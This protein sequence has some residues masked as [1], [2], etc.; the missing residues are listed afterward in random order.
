MHV[1]A[2]NI[3]FESTDAKDRVY[4]LMGILTEI[5]GPDISNLEVDYRKS[6]A[7]VYQSISK[8]LIVISNKLAPLSFFCRRSTLQDGLASW[9][10]ACHSLYF[11]R[12]SW[13]S[14]TSVKDRCNPTKSSPLNIIDPIQLSS[15]QSR[16]TNHI[17][18]FIN[19]LQIIRIP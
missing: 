19:D 18:C 2:T 3:R 5:L 11:C 8:H 12:I 14:S 4:G 1:L 17:A 15:S 9:A 7:D 16:R 13:L 10:A 6:T